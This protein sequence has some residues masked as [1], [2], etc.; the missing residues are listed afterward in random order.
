MVSKPFLAVCLNP[1]LQKTL[2]FSSLHRDNVN[3]ALGHRLDIAGK[4]LNTARVLT[5]LGKKA[6]H[7][8]QL[9]GSFRPIFLDLCEKE[10]LDIRW[11]ESE[12]PIRF[13]YTAIDLSDKSVTEL[14]EEGS[15]VA[16]STEKR[17]M[18]LYLETL[19]ES[20]TLIISGTKAQGFS[21]A[22]LPNMVKEATEQGRRVILDI[23][24]DDLGSSLQYDPYLIKPNLEEFIATYMPE[25]LAAYRKGELGSSDLRDTVAEV[26]LE[27]ARVHGCRIV[28]TRGARSVW[29]VEEGNFSEIEIEM[30]EPVNTI[31]SGDAFTAGLASALEDG[32]NL[33]EAVQEGARCGRLNALQLKPGSIYA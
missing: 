10:A 23:K 1:T 17:I 30:V 11:A 9:G 6:I 32:K 22:I 3:R 16:P 31:G 8:T 25:L 12:S 14:V 19:P 4:G 20:G 28:L 29:I 26:A 13:C 33:K 24:G 18:D 21:P 15:P 2:L 27:L 7:L 5:Q